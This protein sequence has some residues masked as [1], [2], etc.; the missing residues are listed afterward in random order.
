MYS[1][2]D[3]WLGI[4]ELS[5]YIG[6]SKDAIRNWIKKEKCDIPAHKIGKQW[7]FKTSEIDEWIKS[8]HSSI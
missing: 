8:G 3:R 5:E 2:Q 7:K 4:E 6:V 1:E